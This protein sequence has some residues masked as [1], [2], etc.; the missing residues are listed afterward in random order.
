M[1]RIP[2]PNVEL[3]ITILTAD[4]LDFKLFQ[5]NLDLLQDYNSLP[6]YD[7]IFESKISIKKED[8]FTIKYCD[9]IIRFLILLVIAL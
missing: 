9:P 3:Y 2:L 5:L 6:W 4:E 8:L 1:T 7:K